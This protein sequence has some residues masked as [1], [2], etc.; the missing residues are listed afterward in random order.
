[1][2]TT[3]EAAGHRSFPAKAFAFFLHEFRLVLPPTIFFALG[4]N[5]IVFTERLILAEYMIEFGGYLVAV[6]MA[7]IVGK[8]VLVADKMPI[9]RRFDHAPLIVPILYKTLVY[10][11]CVFIARLIE[12]MVS[13]AID[14]GTIA[15]FLHHVADEFSWNRFLFVQTWILVLFL[16]YT[17]AAE[18]ADLLGDG[19]L[20]RIFFRYRPT[21]LK[22]TRRERIR[23]LVRLSDLGRRH[24]AA[25]LRNPKSAAHAEAM[26]L[27]AE[28]A[29]EKPGG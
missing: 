22:R 28:L 15:G 17:T 29:P 20:I 23:T 6:M 2:T 26:Q 25:E 8:A 18:V 11:I 12:E 7:L 24:G 3:H 5:L 16:L 14:S 13:Y 1:M 19:E 4:F 21:E 10:W 9:L 27:V